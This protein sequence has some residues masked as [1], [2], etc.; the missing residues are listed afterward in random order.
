MFLEKTIAKGVQKGVRNFHYSKWILQ[1]RTYRRN[2]DWP[3]KNCSANTN[4][5][6][7]NLLSLP[8]LIPILHNQ[9]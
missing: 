6:I 9:V 2:N 1:V 4:Q 8:P 5:V 3:L 7:F